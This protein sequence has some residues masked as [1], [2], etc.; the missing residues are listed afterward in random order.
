MPEIR[1]AV[2]TVS[3]R[4]VKADVESGV[5]YLLEEIEPLFHINDG[6]SICIKPNL[7][8]MKRSNTG[9][10]TDPALISAV[11]DFLRE[12]WD[13]QISI[14]ESN[15]NLNTIDITFEAL[16]INK[17]ASSKG[18]RV[19]NLS[20]EEKVD[21]NVDGYYLRHIRLPKIL[22]ESDCMLSLAKLKTSTFTTISCVLKNQFGC[23]PGSKAKF[24]HA[25]SEVIAD[26]NTVLRPDVSLVDGRVALDGPGPITG[27]PVRAGVIF[28]G[29][30]PVAVDS[31]CA[32]SMGFNPRRISHIVLSEK[33]GV[34]SMKSDLNGEMPRMHFKVNSS[35][36]K[37]TTLFLTMTGRHPA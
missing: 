25:I 16:G 21:V 36:D 33:A 2:S 1:N 20:R 10:T 35:I 24:H 23:I 15:G 26:I 12:R 32:K 9:V 34:G 28:A 8:L 37:L 6:Y 22:V 29:A 18:T 17:L 5:R 7:C 30:D 13:V 4:P 19:V 11:I 27:T 3:V 14:V 31:A